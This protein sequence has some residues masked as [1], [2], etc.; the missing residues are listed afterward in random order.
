MSVRILTII[1]LALL[2]SLADAAT[3]TKPPGW[4]AVEILVFRYAG[5]DAARGE[6]WP[7]TVP[8][9]STAG[10]I[11]PRALVK[12]PYAKLPTTSATMT[13]TEARLRSSTGY[14]PV[15]E[16]GWRQPEAPASAATPVSITPT[17]LPAPTGNNPSRVSVEGTVTVVTSNQRPNVAV[18]LRLCEP[19]PP[20]LTIETAAVASVPL[21]ASA[22]MP[23]SAPNPQSALAAA[24]G[25]S[26][27]CFALKQRRFVTPDQLEYFDNPA[28]GALVLVR[29]I[30][31]P[32]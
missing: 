29:P 27:L 14:R 23:I 9:P 24:L 1:A 3:T 11:Y 12:G 2:A 28:F 30:N 22:A 19:A 32:E 17:L 31:P 6:T 15:A 18:W 13:S 26:I 7:A 20:D 25:P 8:A 4:Y 21:P 5:P 10:A 16:L